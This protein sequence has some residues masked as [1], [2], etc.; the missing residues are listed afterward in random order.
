MSGERRH[1]RF[2]AGPP[3]PGARSG[4]SLLELVF[5]LLILAG[6]LALAVPSLRGFGESRQVRDTA[7]NVLALA[8]Y[9]RFRA[10]CEGR[11]YRLHIDRAR[12]RYWLETVGEEGFERPLCSFGQV[13]FFPETM[14]VEWFD[15]TAAERKGYIAFAPN[16][17]ADAARLHLTG[18]LG[19]VIAV[20][21]EAPGE[22]FRI[23]EVF[24]RGVRR[25]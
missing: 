24:E 2:R 10:V 25:G 23:R 8:K 14:L 17:R 18:R 9:A 22:P 1:P 12:G 11:E 16:G 4:F 15:S 6:V 20:G 19:T 21:C 5:V 13:F 3:A 7:G